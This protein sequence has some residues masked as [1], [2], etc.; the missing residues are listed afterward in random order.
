MNC[1]EWVSR[2]SDYLDGTLIGTKKQEADAHLDECSECHQKFQRYRQILSSIAAQPRSSLPI[3]MRKAPFSSVLPRLDLGLNHSRWQR[4]PWYI[5]TPL[6]ATGIVLLTL[7]GVSIGPQVRTIYE[8]KIEKNLGDLSQAFTDSS[9]QDAPANS[10]ALATQPI[11]SAEDPNKTSDEFSSEGDE[12]GTQDSES[13]D[14]KVGNSDIWRFILR[15][16]SPQDLRPKIS[17]IL[18]TLAGGEPQ[19]SNKIEGILAPGGIQFDMVLLQSA[20]PKLKRQLFELAPPTPE[21]LVDTPAGETFTWYKIKSKQ[22][23]PSGK[24]RVVIWISQI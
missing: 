7:A 4:I 1:F 9:P 11:N 3:S 16:D 2:S 24:A 12:T 23:I 17:A 8:K 13:E 14:I 10:S 18:K 15:T 5:R 19:I 6:E 21:G 22:K 20:V